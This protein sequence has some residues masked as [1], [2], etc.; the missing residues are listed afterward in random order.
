M[1]DVHSLSSFYEHLN[2][3]HNAEIMK[4]IDNAM[5]SSW[6]FICDIAQPHSANDVYDIYK[7]YVD[8]YDNTYV[9]YKKYNS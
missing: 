2:L 9:L 6:D 8:T 7:M 4:T 1:H 3:E 5:S